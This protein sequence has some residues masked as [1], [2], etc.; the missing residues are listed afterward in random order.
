MKKKTTKKKKNLTKQEKLYACIAIGFLIFVLSAAGY[1]MLGKYDGL[2]QKLPL[3]DHNYKM[4]HVLHHD[5]RLSYE[6]EEYKSVTGIDVSVFQG[7]ID[8]EAVKADGVD[9]AIIRLGY[10]GSGSGRIPCFDWHTA[11]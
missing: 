2:G 8:W 9:F 11:T 6:D 5:G 10:R 1:F 7:N 3:S 4:T